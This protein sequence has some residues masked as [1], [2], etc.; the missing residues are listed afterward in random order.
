MLRRCLPLAL[1]LALACDA[2]AA[3]GPRPSATA[4]A[5]A[6][7]EAVPWPSLPDGPATLGRVLDGA[8]RRPTPTPDPV[9][10]ER[11]RAALRVAVRDGVLAGGMP[12]AVDA[13]EAAVEAG[14]GRGRH[15]WL[16]VGNHHDAAA[17]L[18]AFRRL[19]GPLGLT[20][21]PLTAVEL[22]KAD[23]AWTGLPLDL[24]RGDDE[25]LNRYLATGAR[26]DL[27]AL[28]ARES[29]TAWK[30]GDRDGLADL[31]VGARASG[32]PLMGC[33]MPLAMQ[34]RLRETVG[35]EADRL[36][37]LHCALAIQRT[38]AKA[39]RAT[40]ALLIGEAHLDG[41][42]L[43]RF[44][45][46]G[47]TL[48]ELHLFGGRPLD[49]A[50]VGAIQV[51][52]PLLVPLGPRRLAL[53]LAAPPLEAPVDRLRERHPRSE[54][55]PPRLVVRGERARLVVGFEERA[56]GGSYERPSAHGPLPFL[57]EQGDRILAGVVELPA[58]GHVVLDA[59]E[60]EA[61]AGPLRIEHHE[62]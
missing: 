45:P 54:L 57:L 23:G 21:A 4:V 51:T 12:A 3:P 7:P 31:V 58:R 17:Q 30:F 10:P 62:P 36:R 38:L 53:L 1:L 20:P 26:A 33:D 29:Y 32:R 56:I 43:P 13:L 6:A 41:E 24:Q 15:T 22:L 50:R 60:W 52:T 11:L 46:A 39:P 2:P 8:T 16:L 44:L 61:E 40:V 48:I 42:R 37:D 18:D 5:S 34:S 27:E 25:V 47:D 28:Q 59:L 55:G 49:A 14:S 35:P 19:T 9:T